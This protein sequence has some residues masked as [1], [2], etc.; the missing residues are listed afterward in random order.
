VLSGRVPL[1]ILLAVTIVVRPL[2]ARPANPRRAAQ[3]SPAPVP[4]ADAAA[5]MEQASA[6][7]AS[8]K[9]ADAATAL[10]SARQM[11]DA[12]RAAAASDAPVVA[13]QPIV[14]GIGIPVPRRISGRAPDYPQSAIAAGVSG[15]VVVDVTIDKNGKVRDVGVVKSI[16]ELDRAAQ[17]AARSWKFDPVVVS[18]ARVEAVAPAAI[19]FSFRDDAQ[20]G[21]QLEAAILH[22]R[23]G[24][25][26]AAEAPAA[27]AA[28]LIAD[29]RRWYEGIIPIRPGTGNTVNP[30]RKI[31]DVRPAYPRYA[32]A[33]RI[34]GRVI[35]E[36]I[37]DEQGR[38][39]AARVLRSVPLLDQAALD[40]VRQWEYEPATLNNQPMRMFMTVTVSFNLR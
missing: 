39:R 17:A 19:L 9:L 21:Q 31:K 37:V 35:I 7:Y 20:P 40:A 26:A 36:A 22:A 15:V 5:L 25:F 2:D 18:G 28:A 30:P 33:A 8:R 14:L 11:L 4:A 13:G 12:A 1:G 16:P 6:A 23:R 27:A 38:V 29:E 32:Q 10:A 34:S 3:T 24:R